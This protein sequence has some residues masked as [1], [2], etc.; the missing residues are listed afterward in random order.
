M[1]PPNFQLI[2]VDPIPEHP[3]LA[4]TPTMRVP[5]AISQTDNVYRAMWAMLLAVWQHNQTQAQKIS[6]VACPGLGTAT[7]RVP[8]ARAAKQMALAYQYFLNPP[9]FISWP[10]ATTRQNAIACQR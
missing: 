10:L 7:G 5:M 2:L 8:Y 9:E 3:F 1:Q 6:I 4:H